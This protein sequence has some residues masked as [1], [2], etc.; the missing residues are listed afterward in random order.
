MLYWGLTYEQ[1]NEQPLALIYRLFLLNQIKPFLPS[2]SWIQAGTIAA[3][4][5]NSMAGRKGKALGYDDIFPFMREDNAR[6]I[7]EGHDEASQQALHQK[8]NA[9]FG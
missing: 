7:R 2:N 9:M 8:L 4:T 5:Y 6:D 3:A 1:F